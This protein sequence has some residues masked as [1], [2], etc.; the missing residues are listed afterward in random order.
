MHYVVAAHGVGSGNEVGVL[1][2]IVGVEGVGYVAV[3]AVGAVK[4]G[5]LVGYG[6]IVDGFFRLGVDFGVDEDNQ[7]IIDFV[8]VISGL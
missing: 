5:P 1:L 4:D 6:T 8:M 7:A 2:G 3:L